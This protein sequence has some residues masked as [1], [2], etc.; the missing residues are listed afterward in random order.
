[1]PA[2]FQFQEVADSEILLDGEDFPR[3]VNR[4][5]TSQVLRVSFDLDTYAGGET[6]TVPVSV[7][8]GTGSATIS[9]GS[10]T[11]VTT[12]NLVLSDA[13]PVAL[14]TVSGGADAGDFS[15]SFGASD[16]S[17]DSADFEGIGPATLSFTN[18]DNE[19][20]TGNIAPTEPT[21]TIPSDGASVDASDDVRFEWKHSYDQDK[22][23]LQYTLCFAASE[24]MSNMRCTGVDE[25]AIVP[26]SGIA[27]FEMQGAYLPGLLVGSVLFVML[28][29]RFR[30]PKARVV[31]RIMH[32]GVLFIVAALGIS[33]CGDQNLLEAL[34]MEPRPSVRASVPAET[35]L[36]PGTVYWRVY[37]DDSKGNITA[38]TA[39]RS[40]DVQ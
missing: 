2:V 4:E 12:L 31:R 14:L 34:R 3:A 28:W 30:T 16:S 38:S 18:N 33:A 10:D 36:E 26:G 39:T 20:I 22:D 29:R 5:G 17:T 11:D 35:L 8:S 37:A 24:T 1:M 21:L 7:V 40:L 25:D 27:G 9:H 6:V 19:A 23:P 13:E 32:L 15:L